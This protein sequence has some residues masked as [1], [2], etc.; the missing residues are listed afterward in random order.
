M[1]I[2]VIIHL[3]V[4][5]S[6]II[7]IRNRHILPDK[8]YY[9]DDFKGYTVQFFI[10]FIIPI[11]NLVALALLFME[12]GRRTETFEDTC[13]YKLIL[14]ILKIDNKNNLK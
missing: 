13:I 4:M 1:F 12:Y 3:L 5:V 2:L 11:V 14:K 9:V 6:G 7:A 8:Y 10:A